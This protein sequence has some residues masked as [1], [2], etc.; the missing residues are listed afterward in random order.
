MGQALVIDTALGEQSPDNGEY[1]HACGT[2]HM[3]MGEAFLRLGRLAEADREET[4]AHATLRASAAKDPDNTAPQR[5]L[6][7]V[8]K[9]QGDICEARQQPAQ[10]RQLYQDAVAGEE[11]FGRKALGEQGRHRDPRRVAGQTRRP[12]PGPEDAPLR[13]RVLALQSFDLFFEGPL[14]V[15]CARLGC[16]GRVPLRQPARAVKRT[17]PDPP[18]AFA[19][20]EHGGIRG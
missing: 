9:L 3:D 4:A 6:L 5:E 19:R 12:R 15:G 17:A 7:N 8:L 18:D 1:P 13:C 2:Y 14:L 11:A 20:R 16:R 10:A